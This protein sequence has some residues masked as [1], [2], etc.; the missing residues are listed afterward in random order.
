LIVGPA[1]ARQPYVQKEWQ[2]ALALD[3]CVNPIIRLNGHTSDGAVVDGYRLVP[4]EI[5]WLLWRSKFGVMSVS[6][7]K[8]LKELET[9]NTPLKKLLAESLRENEV[10]REALRRK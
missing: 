1:A 8:R 9:E 7:A 5:G 2:E 6:D 10:T 4:D 3:K